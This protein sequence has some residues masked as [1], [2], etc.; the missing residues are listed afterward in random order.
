MTETSPV[1]NVGVSDYFSLK[2]KKELPFK[3]HLT[4]VLDEFEGTDLWSEFLQIK[5][6]CSF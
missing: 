5:E 2:V 4:F 1:T 3:Y 6:A